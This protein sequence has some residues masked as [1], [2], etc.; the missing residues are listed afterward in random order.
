MDQENLCQEVGLWLDRHDRVIIRLWAWKELA[1]WSR[2]LD[3][4]KQNLASGGHSGL[5]ESQT[6]RNVLI[7]FQKKL[8]PPS[9]LDSA[10][11]LATFTRFLNI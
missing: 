2:D 8:K 5:I 9:V 4:S 11:Y 10:K 1:M 7:K 3:C 6:V